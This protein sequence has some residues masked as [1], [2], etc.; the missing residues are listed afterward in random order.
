MKTHLGLVVACALVAGRCM[1]PDAACGQSTDAAAGAAGTEGHTSGATLIRRG[2]DISDRWLGREGDATRNG[3]YL[4][5][6]SLVTGAGFAAGPGYRYW[7][8]EQMAV[9]DASAVYSWRGYKGAQARVEFPALAQSR[10][11]LTFGTQYRW[12]DLAQV[13]YFGRGPM[14]V[15]TNWSEY[16]LISH[17]VVGYASVRLN[18]PW[19]LRGRVGWL[20]GPALRA[21]GG[22][23]SRHRPSTPDVFAGEAG[24]DKAATPHYRYVELAVHADTRDKPGRPRRGSLFRS[25]LGRITASD[26]QVLSLLRYEL[27]GAR[28][29][30]VGATRLTLA[31]RGWMTLTDGLGDSAVPFYLLPS[32]GGNNTLRA[33]HNYRF[34]DQHLTVLNAE[35]RVR[36]TKSADA[37]VFLDAGNVAARVRDLNVARTSLG[38]GIRLYSDRTSLARLDL[39]HG[40][41][42]WRVIFTRSDPLN[43]S[44]LLRH[45]A[46]MP[47]V[48]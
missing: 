48:P 42:G 10:G 14:S 15:E 37:A 33:F 30:G 29:V 46:P 5:M 32:L 22:H 44:R 39:A 3:I 41:E 9:I 27:E 19:S 11:R 8:G 47:F 17:D 36:L 34:H 35:A 13:G 45:T 6:G 4:Q 28:F 31:L 2:L 21:P 7:L 18:R 12:Q 25:A 26:P 43:L 23:F 38:V 1:A 40:G 16:R 20:L 24:L